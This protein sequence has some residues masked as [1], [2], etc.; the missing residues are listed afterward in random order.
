[1]PVVSSLCNTNSLYQFLTIKYIQVATHLIQDLYLHKQHVPS[2]QAEA[3][4]LLDDSSTDLEKLLLLDNF[5]MES[6][7]VNCFQSMTVHRI[8][9]QPFTFSDGYNVPP[10]DC[11]Q[12]HQHQVLS[13]EDSYPNALVF[14]PTRFQGKGRAATEI[15]RQWPFWGVPKL[16]W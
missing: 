13:D 12:F 10:G 8:A 4:D 15:G 6:M 9:L 3:G 2:L 11:V 1:M 16:A 5:L 7:R 14:D